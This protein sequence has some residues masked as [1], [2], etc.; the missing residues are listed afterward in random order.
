M[1]K[2]FGQFTFAYL[3]VTGNSTSINIFTTMDD[4]IKVQATHDGKHFISLR[5]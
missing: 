5:M 1:K 4:N 3:A 2:I